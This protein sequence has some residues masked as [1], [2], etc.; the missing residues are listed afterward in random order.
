VGGEL[1]RE[2]ADASGGADDQHTV[3]AV[4]LERVDRR[5]RRDPRQRRGAGRGDVD[6]V[7]DACGRG[8]RDQLG[9][10]A[11]AHGRIGVPEEPED[12]VAR[13]HAADARSG[14]L[15]HA[16]VVPAERD[17]ELVLDHA[18]EH[19]GRD[20]IVDGVDRR[21][22]HAH[23]HLGVARR[24][25]GHVV[26]QDGGLAEAREDERPHRPNRMTASTPS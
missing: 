20:R 15:D 24:G 26:A 8:H 22:L 23:E 10:A 6:A 2:A 21:R 12:G 13:G 18:V 1:D 5:Q 14:L 3:A 25:L 11:V 19:P 16:G 17:R 9:P 7:G 4:E